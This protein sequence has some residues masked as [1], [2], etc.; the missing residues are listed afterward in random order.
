MFL[1]IGDSFIIYHIIFICSQFI[2]YNIN[3]NIIVK[4]TISIINIKIRFRDHEVNIFG[5]AFL[6]CSENIYNK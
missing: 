6:F 4:H 3:N 5:E 2:I 1:S